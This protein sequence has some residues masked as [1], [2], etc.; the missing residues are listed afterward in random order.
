MLTTSQVALHAGAWIETCATC[1]QVNMGQSPSMRGRGLKLPEK[2][3]TDPVEHSVALHAG[4]WIETN[5]LWE[6]M[7]L[8]ERRPPCGGVD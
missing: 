5:W 1:S 3:A 7:D 2:L 4:A 8:N 6:A